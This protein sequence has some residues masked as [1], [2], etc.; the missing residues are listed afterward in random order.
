MLIRVEITSV[1]PCLL[2]QWQLDP[3]TTSGETAGSLD[4]PCS[5]DHVEHTC[6]NYRSDLTDTKLGPPVVDDG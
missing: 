2:V 5:A 4:S 3:A 6:S 1:F